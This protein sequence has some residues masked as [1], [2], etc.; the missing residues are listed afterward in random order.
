[1]GLAVAAAPREPISSRPTPPSTDGF[2]HRRSCGGRPVPPPGGNVVS[3]ARREDTALLSRRTFLST[4]AAVG[5]S[6]ASWPRINRPE[7][8]HWRSQAYT[9]RNNIGNHCVVFKFQIRSTKAAS[10]RKAIR[11][12][13]P[14][15][16]P[17]LEAQQLDGPGWSAKSFSY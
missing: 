10:K 3:P 5:A 13:F 8:C 14:G 11:P 17:I 15:K 1:M 2:A 4:T 6:S 9:R 7:R 12:E 16:P